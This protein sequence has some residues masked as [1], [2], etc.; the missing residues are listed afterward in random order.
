[1]VINL[2]GSTPGLPISDIIYVNAGASRV[3]TPWLDALT[4]GG[5]LIFPLT[6]DFST[7]YMLLV[8]G[9]AAN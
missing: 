3:V 6:A 7:G 8:I 5:R 1:M 2:S 9:A 4:D